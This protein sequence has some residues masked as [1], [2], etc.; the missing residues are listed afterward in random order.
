MGVALESNPEV[1]PRRQDQ[2]I[3]DYLSF[4]AV[5]VIPCE[6]AKTTF[7]A[8]GGFIVYAMRQGLFVSKS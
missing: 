2:T 8:E 7:R 3:T 6:K 4:R 5:G 1:W